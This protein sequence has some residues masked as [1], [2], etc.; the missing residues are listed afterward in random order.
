MFFKECCI[1]RHYE[2]I[3]IF[4]TEYVSLKQKL[5]GSFFIVSKKARSP[6]SI[7]LIFKNSN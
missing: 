4:E 6:P 1:F 5:L 7:S 2:L 3:T